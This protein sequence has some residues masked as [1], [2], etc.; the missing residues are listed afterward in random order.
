MELLTPVNT[1]NNS[2]LEGQEISAMDLAEA[3]ERLY[4]DPTHYYKL[5]ESGYGRMMNQVYRW[6]EIAI[7]WD[8]LFQS[9]ANDRQHLAFF[10]EKGGL[11]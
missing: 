5:A 7:R 10:S 9:M 2:F 4:N 3:L 1:V 8:Q 11:K 6:S